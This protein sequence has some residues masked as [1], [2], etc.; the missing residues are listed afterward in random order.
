M[1]AGQGNIPGV[2]LNGEI[3]EVGGG[4]APGA[5]F[6]SNPSANTWSTIAP[7]PTT[8]G[9]CQAG[10]GF[11]QDNEL[12]IV[13]CLG[14]PINQ[15]V[16]IYNPGSNTWRPGPQYSQSHE[17]GSATSLF[18]GANAAGGGAGGAATTSVESTGPC[19]TGTPTPTPTATA[20]ATFTPTPTATA[21]F[22]PTP[23]P[24]ATFTPTPTP[25]PTPLV[26][27][28]LHAR[29]YKVHGL[30]TVDLFWSGPTSG[31][32]DIYRNGALIATVPNQGGSYTDHLNRN[33]RG[34]YTYR[35]CQA[36]TGN[37]SNQVTV[38]FGSG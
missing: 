17:G 21:T 4:T 10:G 3:Y 26:Q 28:T 2:L 37:C 18:N 31:F 38:R 8:S 32:I 11:V 20:T 9:M 14:L 33:G 15:Q 22:T 13:G 12:W 6:A 16:W 36:G 1:P 24:S 5:Q 27:I 7:L 34:T 35:V 25:T 19:Q 30:Q 29:G 23:T